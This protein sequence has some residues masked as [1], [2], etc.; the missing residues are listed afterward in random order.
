M[1]I[2]DKIT[3][4]RLFTIQQ[5]KESLPLK[6]IIKQVD[7]KITS[8]FKPDN[9]LKNYHKN[10]PFLIAEIKKASPSKGVIRPNFKVKDLASSYNN[11][12]YVK[13]IS[14]LTEP[15]FFQGSID[16]LLLAQGV[17]DKPLLMKDF[18]VDEYQIYQGFL[19]GA[20]AFL[21]IGR[22]L[23]DQKIIKFKKVADFLNLKILF[24]VHSV[25]DYQRGIDLG[26]EIVGINNRDLITFETDISTTIQ[27]LESYGKPE[28]IFI[29]SESGLKSNQDI[30]TLSI[31]G[32]DGFLVGEHFMRQTN[33]EQA[34]NG[35]MELD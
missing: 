17:T 33:I 31:A 15:D 28:N 34:I 18:I 26:M 21:L 4:N 3:K 23:D 27:I 10:Q 32:V 1:N 5:E 6:K 13:A 7:Q 24:E 19:Q 11:S 14:V 30:A 29:I 9:F 2:L 16:N 20:A 8:G 25:S 35:L 22:L 12:S